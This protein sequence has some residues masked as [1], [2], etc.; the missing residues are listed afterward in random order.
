[1]ADDTRQT[2]DVNAQPPALRAPAN[3][4]PGGTAHTAGGQKTDDGGPSYVDAVR[5]LGPEYYLNFH[6]RPCVRDSQLQG[7]AAGFAGGSLAAIIGSMW[8]STPTANPHMCN[9]IAP[10]PT[11]T[12][13]QN[14]SSSHLTGPLRPGA[15][16]PWSHTK[17]ANTIDRKK[18]PESNKHK[19]SWRKNAPPSK[20]RRRH[21]GER[22][23]S[24]T[25]RSRSGEMMR[26][27]ERPGV[28][29]IRKI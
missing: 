1:M 21:G 5:S 25:A 29:G 26:S 23:K 11:L 2:V 12:P 16:Y 15:A 17:Y 28:I 18:K 3:I 14:L 8:L 13:L 24:M 6:K 10:D 20:R 4:M 19:N 22:G 9:T 7:I 27:G